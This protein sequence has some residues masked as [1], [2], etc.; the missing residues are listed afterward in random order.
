MTF[1]PT[2]KRALLLGN[3]LSFDSA[4]LRAASSVRRHRQTL[5]DTLQSQFLILKRIRFESQPRRVL[6]P[7]YIHAFIRMF[8]FVVNFLIFAFDFL[9]F[10][11]PPIQLYFFVDFSVESLVRSSNQI[12]LA[13]KIYS[14]IT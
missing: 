7:S 9:P 12:K 4:T 3:D 1:R 2:A 11:F 5:S 8:W 10:R 13:W 14:L 6:K